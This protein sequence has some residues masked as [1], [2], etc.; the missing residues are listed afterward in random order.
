MR[1]REIQSFTLKLNDLKEYENVR[2]ERAALKQQ[3]EQQQPQTSQD[4]KVFET[5]LMPISK[6]GGKNKQEIR[7]RIGFVIP[8]D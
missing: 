7:E 2:N 1:K 3:Q 8:T 4:A 6:F 5:P